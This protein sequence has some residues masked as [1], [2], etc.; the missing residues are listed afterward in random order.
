MIL[1]F[2][3]DIADILSYMNFQNNQ[4]WKATNKTCEKR[5]GCCDALCCDASWH[6][7]RAPLLWTE[8]QQPLSL[9]LDISF[10]NL[11]KLKQNQIVFIIFRLIWNV[12]FQIN[13]KMINTIWF[14]NDLIRFRKHMSSDRDQVFRTYPWSTGRSLQGGTAPWSAEWDS[15]CRTSGRGRAQRGIRCGWWTG[16]GGARRGG[17][18]W[19]GLPPRGRG[20]WC[21]WSLQLPL[22]SFTVT[23][24]YLYYP[25]QLPLLFFT[26]T[27]IMPLNIYYPLSTFWALL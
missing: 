19:C 21:L 22:L 27:F 6:L 13:R 16:T 26:V 12:W 3:D 20:C 18:P 17:G 25:L 7:A 14:R 15:H 24:S 2:N 1:E 10:R 11:I 23:F 8:V 4:R 9:S 5:L